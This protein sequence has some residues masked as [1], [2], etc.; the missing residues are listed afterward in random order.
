MRTI[1]CALFIALWAEVGASDF[2]KPS[3]TKHC[4]GLVT[5]SIYNSIDQHLETSHALE[6]NT[7]LPSAKLFFISF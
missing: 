4:Q 1:I 5:W 7:L 2:R 3:T 6:E